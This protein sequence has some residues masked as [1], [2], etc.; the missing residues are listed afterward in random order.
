M[1]LDGMRRQ[2]APPGSFRANMFIRMSGTAVA[3]LIILAVSPLLTRLFTPEAFGAL[4]V[5]MSLTF[6]ATT[7][8]TL[9]YDQALMLPKKAEDA[10][11]LFW[12]ALLSVGLVSA[13]MLLASAVFF[14]LAPEL[15]RVR[16]VSGWVI[17][18]PF[19]IFLQGLH[20]TL[21][22]WSVR[23][24]KFARASVSQVVRAGSMSGVQL[25]AGIWRA[26]SQGLVGGMV[27]GDALAALSA[28]WLIGRADWKFLQGSLAWRSIRGVARQY[29]DFPLFSGACAFLYS[30]SKHVPVFLLA[31]LFGPAVAGFYAVAVRVLQAPMNFILTSL[32]QVLFQK[33]SEVFNQNGDTYALFRRSTA[34]L[35]GIAVLPA[36]LLL[37]FGP[38]LFSFALGGQWR[39]AGEYARWMTP[40]LVLGF[41]SVPGQLFIQIYR[42]QGKLLVQNVAYVLFMIAAILAGGWR[43]DALLAVALSSLIGMLYNA[44]LIIWAASFLRRAR[45]DGA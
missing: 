43:H 19:S 32:R 40:W 26:G 44:G 39:V 27:A 4:G 10:A 11:A 25:G 33:A 8:V 15:L 16:D 7:L 34:G 2:V 17:L 28:G 35:L 9:R 30:L 23:R 41:A 37:A 22:S 6:I 36:L 18:V 24:K 42:K 1:K 20:A 31:A 14:R 45:A 3:Q 13:C 12:A 5:F 38:R 29:R 21:T